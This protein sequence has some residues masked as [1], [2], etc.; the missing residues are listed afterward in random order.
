MKTPTPRS[1]AAKLS[2]AKLRFFLDVDA[3]EAHEASA[4]Q[5]AHGNECQSQKG[6]AKACQG[7]AA[8]K[9]VKGEVEHVGNAVFK[10]AQDKSHDRQYNDQR[11]GGALVTFDADEHEHAAKD[12]KN[13]QAG[14]TVGV[15]HVNQGGCGNGQSGGGHG[16]GT[17]NATDQVA[18]PNFSKVLQV[19]QGAVGGKIAHLAGEQ[20]ELQN[21]NG[22]EAEREQEG[23]CNLVVDGKEAYASYTNH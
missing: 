10:S 13:Q 2:S 12:S 17:N 6:V 4:D 15:F 18:E 16:G 7:N 21:N 5:V 3:G 1:G 8:L 19:I 9:E 11:V 20:V 23:T 14:Q 22:V